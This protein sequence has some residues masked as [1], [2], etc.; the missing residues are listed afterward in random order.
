MG[1]FKAPKPKVV[2]RYD[3]SDF[4]AVLFNDDK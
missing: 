4:E 2:F 1:N 3:P